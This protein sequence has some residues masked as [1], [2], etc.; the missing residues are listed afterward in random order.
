[1]KSS[2]IDNG[3]VTGRLYFNKEDTRVIIKRPQGVGYTM[4]LGNKNTWIFNIIV[5][6][7]IV[8]VVRIL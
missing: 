1:M 3:W 7:I 6:S 4:N 8:M 2:K 5:V